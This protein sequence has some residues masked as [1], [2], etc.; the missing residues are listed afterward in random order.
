MD[1]PTQARIFEP[2]FTTK[3]I[4]KGTGLGLSTVYGIVEQSGG[5]VWVYSAV[6]VGTTFKIHLPRVDERATGIRPEEQGPPAGEDE[7]ALRELL[8]EA[9]RAN[10]YEVVVARD[11][12]DAS[13]VAAA[14]EGVI[15]VMVT[16][17]I[18]PGMTGPKAVELIARTRPAMKV[19][20]IS[21]YSDEAVVRQGLVAPGRAFINKPFGPEFLLRRVRDVLEAE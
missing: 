21:G 9:L 10:G 6:G 5:H 17:V 16:D 19:L 15:D 8:E 1:A 3:E 18:M 2:F 7:T 12:A 14:H 4:G 11:G 20:Y 13:R